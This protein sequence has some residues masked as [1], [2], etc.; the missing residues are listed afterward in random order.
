MM[1]DRRERQTGFRA[2]SADSCDGPDATQA[3]RNFTMSDVEYLAHCYANYFNVAFDK[4]DTSRLQLINYKQLKHAESFADILARGF[5]LTP[6]AAELT[7][8]R[9]QYLYYSKDDSDTTIFSG[10]ADTMLDILPVNSKQIIEQICS[11]GLARLD[12]SGR[13]LFPSA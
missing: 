12:K 5:N 2:V 1:S 3:T 4:V 8:M 9:K 11:E 13:N 7:Q 10:D 6:D